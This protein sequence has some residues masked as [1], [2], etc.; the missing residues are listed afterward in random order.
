VRQDLLPLADLVLDH[1]RHTRGIVGEA[2]LR[3]GHEGVR[4]VS[5]IVESLHG[6]RRKR[7]FKKPNPD[8]SLWDDLPSAFRSIRCPMFVA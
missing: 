7:T 5:M 4:S 3:R 1:E 6:G 2:H 8:L